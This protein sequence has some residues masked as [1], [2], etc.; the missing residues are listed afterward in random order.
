MFVLDQHSTTAEQE[1]LDEWREVAPDE[2]RGQTEQ[3]VSVLRRYP[4]DADN[5]K[6]VAARKE[7][8]A[9]ADDHCPEGTRTFP[10][11]TTPSS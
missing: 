10:P 2:I 9:Y 11:R 8:E 5:P 4:V 6:L 3:A 7:I 1:T